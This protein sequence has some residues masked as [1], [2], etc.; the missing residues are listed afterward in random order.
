MKKILI[1]SLSYHPRFIGGAEVAIKEITDRINS[2]DISFDMV[3]LRFDSNLPTTEKIGNVTIYRVGFSKI[4]PTISDLGKF[5]LHLN[6]FLFQFTAVWK[7]CRLH[8]KNNYDG[9][10]AMMAHSC[11]VPA[12]LFNLLYSSVPYVLTLQEG[13][14][15]EYIK[16]KMLPIYPLFVLGFKRAKILQ[17]IST[18]LLKWGRD[19][20]FTGFGLVVPNAVDVK[21]FSQTFSSEAQL[22][23]KNKVGKKDG[24]ILMITT[25][26]LVKKNAVDDVIK[27]LTYLPEEYKFLVIGI[28]SDEKMLKKLAQDS[29]VSARVIF[30]G[31]VENKEIPKYLKISDIFIRPSLSEGF[32]ISFVEAMASGLPVIATQEG[33]I[34]DFLFDPEINKDKEPTGLAVKVRDPKG[35]A[36]QAA[37]LMGDGDL[38]LRLIK[39][40]LSLV[41]EK[42]DWDNISKKMKENVFDRLFADKK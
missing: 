29:G 15:P 2:K 23:L 41:R 13:D 3:T 5:P 7:A 37:R 42:Y 38:R 10:W 14:P 40:G 36:R 32:G 30:L 31:E 18:F 17:T 24:D 9:V 35:I 1:F 8:R 33:G 6:K 26:R 11:A 39:N 21:H 12:G 28:G 20:G 19:M 34:S 4:N 22:E 27:S 25:S 16:K